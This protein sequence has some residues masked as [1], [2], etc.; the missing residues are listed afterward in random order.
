MEFAADD[1][2]LDGGDGGKENAVRQSGAVH[3]VAAVCVSR[4]AASVGDAAEEQQGEE[5]ALDAAVL[6]AALLVTALGGVV[7]AAALRDAVADDGAVAA[8]TGADAKVGGGVY[9]A[10]AERSE[11]ATP[12]GVNMTSTDDGAGVPGFENRRGREDR[13]RL[14]RTAEDWRGLATAPAWV[15]GPP[16]GAQRLRARG[17]PR[18]APPAAAAPAP[19][20]PP[21]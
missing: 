19:P 12:A 7:A 16:G 4:E 20:R 5:A 21:R 2:L 14:A 3:V 9:D 17:A 13:R 8:E 1:A 11:S 15:P 10:D 6:D 18:P